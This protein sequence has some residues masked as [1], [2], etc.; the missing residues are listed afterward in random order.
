MG[1]QH[2]LQED[3]AWSSTADFLEVAV[4]SGDLAPG[5]RGSKT[6][7]RELFLSA[8]L[9][10][11]KAELLG[12]T[13]TQVILTERAETW[14]DRVRHEPQPYRRFMELNIHSLWRCS[15]SGRPSRPIPR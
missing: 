14:I 12:Q 6:R 9:N 13:L 3:S 4:A 5:K 15:A 2:G 7:Q 11:P 10:S 8:Y 1:S